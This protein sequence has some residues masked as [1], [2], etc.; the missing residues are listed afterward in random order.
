SAIELLGEVVLPGAYPV[1]GTV[2]LEEL[3]AAAGGLAPG[4][5]VTAVEITRYPL[6]PATN[7]LEVDRSL[8]DLRTVPPDLIAIGIG[9]TVRVGPLISDRERGFVEIVGEVRRPGRYDIV[10]GEK[11]SS[12]IERA[13][14]L[15]PTAYPA[16]AVFTRES[17]RRTEEAARQRTIQEFHRALIGRI[18]EV[19]TGTAARGSD[20]TAQEVSLMTNLM[21]QLSAEAVVGRMVVEA[22]PL[23]LEQRPE[24]DI[25]LEGGDRLVIPRTP[26][27]VFVS[28]EV[29]NPGAQQFALGMTAAEYIA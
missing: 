7:R 9:N 29:F 8:I 13:G 27:M 26:Q 19:P 15:Q 22:N 28:G 5:D 20:L 18:S 10:R 6:N 1:A 16:G 11:L 25:T 2:T 4:A 3:L 21:E 12:V 17:V 14:G 23:V 24:L